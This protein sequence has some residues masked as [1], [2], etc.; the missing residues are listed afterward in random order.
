MLIRFFDSWGNY[1]TR[2]SISSHT[3]D[4]KLMQAM[5]STPY[6][7]EASRISITATINDNSPQPTIVVNN[8]AYLALP[9]LFTI[10]LK[11]VNSILKETTSLLFWLQDW[12]ISKIVQETKPA[13]SPVHSN[14]PSRT[15]FCHLCPPCNL[16][17][18]SEPTKEI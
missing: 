18:T 15:R 6:T 12:Y 3:F 13:M 16:S 1:L 4:L 2:G 17:L 7:V 14:E 5:S 8:S 9:Q 10:L 11:I